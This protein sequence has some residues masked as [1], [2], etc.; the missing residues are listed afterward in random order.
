MPGS[1]GATFSQRLRLAEPVGSPQVREPGKCSSRGL[2]PGGTRDAGAAG[3]SRRSAA[4]SLPFQTTFAGHR[5]AA[6][7]TTNRD[8][9]SCPRLGSR[10]QCTCR[11]PA[12]VQGPW[13][14]EASREP[15]G[16]SQ[17]PLSCGSGARGARPAL[18]PRPRS[19]L[20]V[21]CLQKGKKALPPSVC[22][23][24]PGGEDLRNMKRARCSEA[25]CEPSG[26]SS[27][28]RG[29]PS[30]PGAHPP[31]RLQGQRAEAGN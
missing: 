15:R 18:P 31:L 16:G 1:P 10:Q 2:T 29:C 25:A 21:K 22:L 23:R 7:L 4:C 3:K 12:R 27:V 11:Q 24:S 28:R 13:G 17:A 30:E 9:A 20:T 19:R 8:S 6:Q 14:L 5:A 26:L